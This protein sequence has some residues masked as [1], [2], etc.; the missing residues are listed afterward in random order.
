MHVSLFFF[1]RGEGGG[2]NDCRVDVFRRVQQPAADPPYQSSISRG[3][4]GSPDAR[5]VSSGG[6]AWSGGPVTPSPRGP[7]G[8]GGYYIRERAAGMGGTWAS[9]SLLQQHLAAAAMRPTPAASSQP[10]AGRCIIS[11]TTPR[12][13]RQARGM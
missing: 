9:C 10:E 1:W 5:G 11:V 13:T 8:V 7:A 12:V 3:G 4:A 6:A 2:R